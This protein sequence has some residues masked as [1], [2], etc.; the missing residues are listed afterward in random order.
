[1]G[2]QKRTKKSLIT[3]LVY[4]AMAMFIAWQLARFTLGT[5][6]FGDL[7]SS[8]DCFVDIEGNVLRP[9]SY[10]VAPGVTQFEILKV[11][12]IR[13]TSDISLFD[14]TRQISGNQ[15]LDVGTM[16]S[17]VSM[18]NQSATVRLEFSMGELNIVAG[19]GRTRTVEE[20]LEINASDRILTEEKAQAEL[21]VNTFSRIDMDEFSELVLDKLN[22][23]EKGKKLIST[24]QKSGVCWNKIVYTTKSELFKAI[25]PFVNITVAGTG[26]DFM[27]VVKQDEIDIHDMDGLLLVERTTGAEAINMISGQSAVIFSDN[28]PF[29]VTQLAS[30]ANPTDRFSILTK[31]KSNFVMRHMPLNFVFCAVPSVYIFF[32]IQFEGGKVHVVHIPG[33]TSVE[34]FVQGC[35]TLD[36][37][38]L[39]GGGVFVS[40]LIEQI[41]DARIP[42]YCVFDKEKVIRVA[43]AIGGLKVDVDEKA[44]SALKVSKG[45]QKLNSTQLV[46]FLKPSISGTEDFEARQ[47]KVI[48]A[49][50]EGL[51]SKN[52]V[53]TALLAQ[54]LITNLETNFTAG[55]IMDHYSKFVT[56]KNWT[57]K[58]Y[59]LPV[60][61]V[62]QNGHVRIDPL[63]EECKT[64]LENK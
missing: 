9:G 57:T 47:T 16:P 41:M 34:E 44:A 60:K 8:N 42:K 63:L 14:L 13:P 52:I 19:D 5:R 18:K 50:F 30:E 48:K 21:S 56:G 55:E 6:D 4:L 12:G 49:L 2:I 7:S 10:R 37:A 45:L 3:F 53:L 51:Q 54:Q 62:T 1:M 24:F 20:G 32:S 43:G 36:Q 58:E 11:A 61:R 26:A 23:D 40:T 38:F 22:A 28:R 27:V 29:Q 46:L 39:Y 25:T 33:G 31:V 35:S 59:A 17:P 64:L 15:Q